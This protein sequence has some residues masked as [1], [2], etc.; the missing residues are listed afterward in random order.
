[1]LGQAL[2]AR[3]PARGETLLRE[4]LG[5]LTALVGSDH[6]FTIVTLGNLSL[7]IEVRGDHQEATRLRTEALARAEDTLGEDH[8]VTAGALVNLALSADSSLAPAQRRL[9]C[10]RAI[11][12]R[13][14][15]AIDDETQAELLETLRELDGSVG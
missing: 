4:A 1:M 10:E 7:A 9:W 6:P 11:A 12:V 2:D 5:E 3:D 8:P 13:A 15:L 14:M